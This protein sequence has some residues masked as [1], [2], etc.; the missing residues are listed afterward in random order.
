MSQHRHGGV[1]LFFLQEEFAVGLEVHFPLC[2][3]VCAG[4]RQPWGGEEL[5]LNSNSRCF[6]FAVIGPCAFPL[7]LG[8]G[9]GVVCR[10]GAGEDGVAVRVGVRAALCP[11]WSAAAEDGVTLRLRDCQSAS[12]SGR[13]FS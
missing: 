8:V 12:N 3:C 4:I 1:G 9:G 6:A 5:G 11:G 10:L 7:G 2:A 13:L